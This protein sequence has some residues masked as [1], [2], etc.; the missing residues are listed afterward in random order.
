MDKT[1]FL[2]KTQ[3]QHLLALAIRLEHT[4]VDDSVRPEEYN[5]LV[6]L[7]QAVDA[8]SFVTEY[9]ARKSLENLI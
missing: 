2:D 5:A 7:A 8:P 3:L 9:F 6:L 4:A 1:Q